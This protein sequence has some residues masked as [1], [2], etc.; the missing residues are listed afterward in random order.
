MSEIFFGEGNFFSSSFFGGQTFFFSGGL[1]IKQTYRQTW[2]LNDY[3][4]FILLWW[5]LL[6]YRYGI[7]FEGLVCQN[8]CDNHFQF[9]VYLS[10]SN[11]I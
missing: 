7:L 2:R 6:Y 5:L 4:T 10:V 3:L 8:T 11:Q 9:L 1:A